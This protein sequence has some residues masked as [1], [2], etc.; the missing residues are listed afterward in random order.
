MNLNRISLD[1]TTISSRKKNSSIRSEELNRLAEIMNRFIET[2]N[3]RLAKL[4]AI[5]ANEEISN[6]SAI[7]QQNTFYPY[8]CNPSNY[9]PNNITTISSVITV[10]VDL[11]GDSDTDEQK[12]FIFGSDNP[13]IK[14]NQK[15]VKCKIIDKRGLYVGTADGELDSNE[16]TINILETTAISSSYEIPLTLTCNITSFSR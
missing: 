4:E 13:P 7:P 3:T 2:T 8:Y 1:D 11:I 15:S 12:I 14:I 9:S 16:Q 10:K 5:I 6:F